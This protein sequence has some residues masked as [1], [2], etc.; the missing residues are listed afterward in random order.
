MAADTNAVKLPGLDDYRFVP[1][2]FEADFLAREMVP[3][4][5]VAEGRW[6]GLWGKLQLD[7]SPLPC[8][9]LFVFQDEPGPMALSFSGIDRSGFDLS[10]A[11]PSIVCVRLDHP[12]APPG[13]TLS[14]LITMTHVAKLFQV[15]RLSEHSPAKEWPPR[16]ST[17]APGRVRDVVFEQ[18]QVREEFSTGNP[19]ELILHLQLGRVTAPLDLI[20]ECDRPVKQ[21]SFFLLAE[22]PAPGTQPVHLA[23][24][25]LVPGGQGAAYRV[26]L[27]Q[28]ELVQGER[29]GISLQSKQMVRVR[30]V[31]RVL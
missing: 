14:F 9:L 8:H 13:A 3:E 15:L 22:L 1:L 20:V 18:R 28:P 19:W 24:L 10:D 26:R 16:P 11:G 23:S 2:A 6:I 4:S 17:L 30:S 25:P 31:K 5:A 27:E 21:P 12:D 7:D 29:V